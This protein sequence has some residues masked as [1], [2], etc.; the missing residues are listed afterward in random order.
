MLGIGPRTRSSFSLAPRDEAGG[1]ILGDL[2]SRGIN[3]VA[4]AAAQSADH[5]DSYFTMLRAELGFY[6]GCL[7]L[8]SQLTS[9]GIAMAFPDPEPPSPLMFSCTDLRY[10]SLALQAPG[11]VVGNDVRGDGK[12]LVIAR[13]K[14]C[15]CGPS[16]SPTGAA[17]TSWRQRS[18][19]RPATA[20]TSTTST[21]D[22]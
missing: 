22:G 1:Q 11:P 18:P 17:A 9:R 5:I 16:V 2:T 15:S 6:V 13:T 14:R 10:V 20:R 7:N 8:A 3:L 4:N 21:A 12:P 19:C